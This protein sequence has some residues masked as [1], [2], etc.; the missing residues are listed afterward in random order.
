MEEWREW[1]EG[2][3]PHREQMAAAAQKIISARYPELVDKPDDYSI[4]QVGRPHESIE[5]LHRSCSPILATLPFCYC[6]YPI[7]R[8][9][10]HFL[11]SNIFSSHLW[12]CVWCRRR[13]RR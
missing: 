3:R 1:Y 11:A 10:L 5:L 6:W 9:R 8:R 4:E 2:K 13:W 12:F 7:R